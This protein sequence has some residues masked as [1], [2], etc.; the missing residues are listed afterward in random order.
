MPKR[1]YRFYEDYPI[2]IRHKDFMFQWCCDCGL[3][4]IHFAEIERGEKPEDDKVNL[5]LIRDD[6]ATNY[7]KDYERLK[8][9]IKTKPGHTPK[10]KRKKRMRKH[11]RGKK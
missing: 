3:R 1:K 7:R 5:Y 2:T 11:K 4:H 9:N 8:K 10:E 6:H